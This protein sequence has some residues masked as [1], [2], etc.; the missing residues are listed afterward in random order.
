MVTDPDDDADPDGSAPDGSVDDED[1]IEEV[2]FWEEVGEERPADPDVLEGDADAL[3][4]PPADDAEDVLPDRAG[5]RWPGE[6]EEDALVDAPSSVV[7][8]IELGSPGEGADQETPSSEIDLEERLSDETGH[9]GIDLGLD[10]D[11]DEGEP[12]EAAPS[13][14]PD[15]EPSPASPGERDPGGADARPDPIPEPSEEPGQEAS[16]PAPEP[17][18]GAGT[19]DEEDGTGDPEGTEVVTE[20]QLG[21]DVDPEIP[22]LRE[23]G[24]VEA[25]PEPREGV[26]EA[27]GPCHVCGEG[28][29]DARYA[30]VSC[31]RPACSSH[32]WV[33]FGLCE[34]CAT[35]EQ[36]RKLRGERTQEDWSAFLAI[37]W[38]H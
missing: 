7:D 6:P 15:D 36:I 1:P 4:S 27:D 9:P 29:E 33:M 37:K 13:A 16:E 23:R 11:R 22:R 3:D 2:D 26:P 30:C 18:A 25:G 20:P 17:G 5:D 28:E 32:M 38:V 19:A 14:S 31:E 34:G 8:D 10:P 12:A 24:P 35:E 21:T